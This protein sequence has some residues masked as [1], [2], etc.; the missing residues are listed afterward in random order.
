LPAS[1]SGLE[2][3]VGPADF[4]SP[5]GI[6]T[7]IDPAPA[8]AAIARTRGIEVTI[9]TAELLPFA[10]EEFDYALMVTTICFVD[11]WVLH[12]VK[13]HECSDRAGA[14]SSVLLTETIR[15][16]PSTQRVKFATR[17]TAMRGS[18]R[19]RKF[20]AGSSR[21]VSAGFG[22]P[23][24]SQA[25]FCSPNSISNEQPV[26]FGQGEGSFVVLKATKGMTSRDGDPINLGVKG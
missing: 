21:L 17:S 13:P 6:R 5:L 16:E 1:G 19:L 25:I 3:G 18:I 14:L 15:W 4:A 24:A 12:S 22:E 2:I 23:V 26:E 10:A 20:V 9:G 8:M 7:G 11:A